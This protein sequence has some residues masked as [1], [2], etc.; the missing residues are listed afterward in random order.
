MLGARLPK[1]RLVLTLIFGSAVVLFL[2]Q[3]GQIGLVDETPPLFA[4]SAR[5]M[6]EQGDWLIP[7]VNGLP[8]YDKP[9][10]VYWLMAALYA[11][12]ASSSW[13]PLGSWAA[14]LPSAM[15]SVVMMLL[16]AQLLSIHL[17]RQGEPSLLVPLVGAWAYGLS[18]LVLLWSRIGV[19]DILF[20]VLLSIALLSSW[21]RYAYHSFP[22]WPSWSF[23]GLAVLTKGPVAVLIFLGSWTLFAFSGRDWS[24]CLASLCLPR[25]LLL[26]LVTSLPWY[27][28]AFAVE[29]EPYWRSFFGYHNLQRFTEV[30]N[31]HAAPWWFYVA[32][33]LVANAP[34]TPLLLL[35]G[36]RAFAVRATPPTTSLQRFALCWLL[37][38]LVFFSLSATKLPSYWLPSTPAAALLIALGLRSPWQAVQRSI[39]LCAVCSIV[40]ALVLFAAPAW[41]PWIRDPELPELSAQLQSLGVLPIGAFI[42]LAFS[43]LALLMPWPARSRVLM[44][45]LGCLLF[46]PAAVLPSLSLGDRIRS[47]PLRAISSQVRQLRQS[48]EALAMVGTIKP[49]LHFYSRRIVAYEGKSP[50][51]LVN[52][53]DRL[54]HE[55]RLISIVTD[56]NSLLLVGHYQLIQHPLWS[57][58]LHRE[59]AQAGPYRLWRVSRP[60]LHRTADQLAQLQQLRPTWTEYRPERF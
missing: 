42:L 29:G 55:K 59:L 43:L 23:L 26:C 56:A 39:A 50:Q 54:R 14:A 44:L 20:S 37:A 16:L 45:Q 33:L 5:G 21:W 3:L 12:P 18:P 48:G 57:P 31:G 7:R 10:L 35:G 38:I 40:L 8:R 9:P 13:D 36:W 24:A 2:W 17:Q 41:L 1:Q 58:L 15:A 22:W 34:F 53:S 46:V 27:A 19:S 4:A 25:G 49:S 52:L 51:A 11:L 47:A 60:A 30:V 28:L 6:V 32:M